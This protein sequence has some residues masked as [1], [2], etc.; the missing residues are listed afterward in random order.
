MWQCDNVTIS[1]KQCGNVTINNVAMFA[2]SIIT[3]A[4]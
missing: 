3:L 1:N 4:H 2:L